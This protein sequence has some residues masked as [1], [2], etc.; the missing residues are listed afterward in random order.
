M[1]GISGE[2]D[3]AFDFESMDFFF[4][5]WR[6]LWA[7]WEG[8]ASARLPIGRPLPW[9]VFLG[10]KGSRIQCLRRDGP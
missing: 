3:P 4:G 8:A 2:A 9:P 6:G 1:L 5:R 7:L 10:T